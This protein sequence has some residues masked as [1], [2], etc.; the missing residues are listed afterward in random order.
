MSVSTENSTPSQRFKLFD[1]T[2]P[3]RWFIVWVGRII[4]ATT[5]FSVREV[6]NFPMMYFLLACFFVVW[7]TLGTL[8]LWTG[9]NNFVFAFSR[10]FHC[11][12]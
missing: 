1:W 10:D 12:I 6:C 4:L 8:I 11:L 7:I 5:T 2:Y 3:V 9:V